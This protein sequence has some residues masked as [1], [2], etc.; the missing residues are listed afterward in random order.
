MG[1]LGTERR[2]LQENFTYYGYNDSST[3]DHIL[4]SEYTLTNTTIMQYMSVGDLSYLS[5]HEP[6]MLRIV[7]MLHSK[8]TKTY[9]NIGKLF[10]R[11]EKFI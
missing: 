3:N 6:L 11:Q 1:E 2:D 10:V 7:S 8:G 9:Q 5:D 4:V